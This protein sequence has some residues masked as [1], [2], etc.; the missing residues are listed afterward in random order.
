MKRQRGFTLLEIL[1][2]LAI[3]SIVALISVIGLRT[4]I[5]THQ[6]LTVAHDRLR[7]VMSAV[8]VIR[9]DVT[10]MVSRPVKDTS[11]GIL[12][13][14]WIRNREQLEFTR[15]GYT[16]PFQ[17]EARSSLQ[18][19]GYLLKQGS[20]YRLTWPVLDRAPHT[21]VARRVIL[22]GVQKMTLNYVNQV[23]ELLEVWSTDAAENDGLPRAMTLLLQLHDL[24]PLYLVLPIRGHVDVE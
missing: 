13:D 8:T 19:V 24:G 20:L 23:G 15:A 22:T 12:P 9:R 17:Q 14:L 4:L 5:Q 3:F 6:R 2:A 21:P 16:N 10:Q 1:I 18:R 7:E 11:G